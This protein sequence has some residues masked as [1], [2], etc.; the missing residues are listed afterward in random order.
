MLL[1][2][3]PMTAIATTFLKKFN[4]SF[5]ALPL[6]IFALGCGGSGDSG[7]SSKSPSELK[8]VAGGLYEGGV[9]R[10]N[11]VEYFRSLYP[12]NVT[13]VVG[14]RIT[15]QIY[16]GLVRLNQAD[17][18]I[19]PC[20][21]ESWDVDSMATTFTFNI[22]KGIMFHDDPCFPEG[23]GREVTAHD[24]KYVMTLL[25][26]P[27][28]TNQGFWVFDN[29]VKGASAYHASVGAGNPLPEGVTGVQVLDDH[30]LRIE[31]EKPFASFLH[32]LAMPF[33]EVF[34][35]EAWDKYGND[36]RTKTVGTGPFTIKALKEDE[37]V[38]LVRN[39]NYWEKDEHGNR[40]PYLN[41]IK[42]TFLKERVSEM[43]EF[44]KG[45]LEM[46][47]QIPLEMTREVIDQN[48]QLIGEYKKFQ[49]QIRPVL[50]VQYYGF[51]H[52]S[53]L[54]SNMNLRKALNYAVDRKKIVE[55]T[56]KGTGKEAYS[57]IVPPGMAGYDSEVVKGYNYD[58]ARAKE[59][60][61]KAGYPNGEGLEELTLQINSGGGRNEQVAEAVQKMLMDNLGITVQITKLPFAQHL[62]NLETGK[63]EFWRSGWVADYPD[64]ENFL[65]LLY[66]VHIPEKLSDKSYIN[67]TR[68]TSA[69]FDSLFKIALQTVDDDKRNLLYMKCDQ[70]A[71][72][73]AAIMPLYYNKDPRM[74]QPY[75]RDFPQNA[76]EYRNLV[77]TNFVPKEL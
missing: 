58:P 12:L 67:S 17:L 30:T 61:A 3:F 24:F 6:I 8:A 54:F 39:P 26:Q 73:E 60:L 49:L 69:R 71:M 19:E 77:K 47:Y 41:G 27:D 4:L 25:C 65:N 23:K 59:Y 64:P 44:K 33:C 37:T 28:A 18:S 43:L 32:I 11:E 14:H 15:N 76:M 5:L 2:N 56:L 55:Y 74:L 22:R 29:R 72:D 52:K 10:M 42:W 36:M 48:D 16:Q 35:K 50:T 7:S 63:V 51:Q 20:L 38:I 40:L 75:V 62:E 68:F 70:I 46:M 53:E 34:P 66:S 1:T 57:G 9:F 13:E 45:N 31:L 21:A